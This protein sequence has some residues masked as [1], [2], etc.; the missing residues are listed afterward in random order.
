[1]N[2]FKTLLHNDNYI[3]KQ[4][5]MIIGGCFDI[6]HPGHLD[7]ITKA[8]QHSGK[9][10]IL[11]EPDEKIKELKGTGRP[12]DNYKLRIKNL[13]K[14]GLVDKI[15]L[16]PVLTTSEDYEKFIRKTIVSLFHCSIA[17]KKISFLFGITADDK[18]IKKNENIER[19]GK[20]M[21]IEVIE[22]NNVLPEH[23]TSKLIL[24]F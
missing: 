24:G 22:V 9:L 3:P 23:S 4:T 8:K 17:N 11:L 16:L 6:L 2:F 13:E 10:I 19:L 20:K 7:F 18:N 5:V 15:V 14:T 1:M 12:I 21:N